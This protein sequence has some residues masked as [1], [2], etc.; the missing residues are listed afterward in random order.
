MFGQ[1]RCARCVALMLAAP[2]L[3]GSGLRPPGW[4]RSAH[5]GGHAGGG[6]GIRTLAEVGKRAPNFVLRDTDGSPHMLFKKRGQIVVLEWTHRRCPAVR[7]HQVR[8]RTMQKTFEQ[9][10]GHGVCWLAIDSSHSCKD[11]V[12]E[13]RAWVKEYELPYPVLLDASGKIGHLYGV[14]TTPHMFVIDREG[15]LVYTGAMDDDPTGQTEKKRNLVLEVVKAL[16]AGST[17]R[18]QPATPHGCPVAYKA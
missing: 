7:R 3:A 10:Q 2:V 1:L 15:Q 12:A 16:L 5:P 4:D 14:E 9:L 18:V 11:E 17:E 8:D 6:A 13:I